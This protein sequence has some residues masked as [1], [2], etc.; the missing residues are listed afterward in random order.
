MSDA[1][2]DALE[3]ELR[4]LAP[5]DPVLEMVGAPVPADSILTK[6]RH[7]I[8]MGSQNKVNDSDEFRTWHQKAGGGAIHA[9]FG[10]CQQ[11]AVRRTDDRGDA[12]RVVARFSLLEH[13]DLRKRG[14]HGVGQCRGSE[15]E[16]R[17]GRQARTAVAS[18]SCR[19]R[20]ESLHWR[21]VLGSVSLTL[22]Q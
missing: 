6:A 18:R 13:G 20:C 16:N 12:K 2:Y 22:P 15:M 10:E 14:G 21:N 19:C 7:S 3:D 17:P 9:T 11:C 4:E 5:H 8:P 1:E